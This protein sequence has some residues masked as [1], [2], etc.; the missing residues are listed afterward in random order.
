MP[1]KYNIVCHMHA[2]LVYGTTQKKH[3]ICL[4][5]LPSLHKIQSA[6]IILNIG[7]CD[8]SKS[9]VHF[10]GNIISADGVKPDTGLERPY[11]EFSHCLKSAW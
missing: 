1:E 5:T 8:V 10:L 9:E 11:R 3:D 2:V 4:H 6:C 7:M